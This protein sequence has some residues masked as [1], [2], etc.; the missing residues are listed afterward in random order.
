M[1]PP[2]YVVPRARE[3]RQASVVR[4]TGELLSHRFDLSDH[5]GF[6][7]M[8]LAFERIPP[9][10]RLAPPHAHTTREEGVF[11]VQGRPTLVIGEE[12]RTLVEGET[13]LFVPGTSLLHTIENETDR[14]VELLTFASEPTDDR[15]VY[16]APR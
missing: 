7:G 3:P 14:D 5:A 10:A 11:V 9:G 12:R 16:S 1:R 8:R 15:T 6:T 4:S 2:F 13:V